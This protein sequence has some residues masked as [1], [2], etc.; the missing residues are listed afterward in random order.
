MATGE[1]IKGLI[2]SCFNNNMEN[3]RAVA[4]QVAAHEAAKGHT[5]LARDIREIVDQ[6]KIKEKPFSKNS[7][8]S[9]N[10][11]GLVIQENSE[12]SQSDLVI[13]PFLSQ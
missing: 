8:F 9:S 3:L 13:S 2:R 12:I 6:K 5:V 4:L 1:Q 10:P 7:V 11:Q